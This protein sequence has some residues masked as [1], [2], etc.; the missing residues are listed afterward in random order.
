MI[1]IPEI[2][3]EIVSKEPFLEEAIA[4]GIINYSALARV[5]KPQI[6]EKLLKRI[7][8]GAILMALKR[9]KSK[10][11]PKNDL[12]K[13]ITKTPEMIVRSD[14][15]EYTFVNSGLVLKKISVILSEIADEKR[16]FI[17][18]TQGV[19]E[20]AIIVSSYWQKNIELDLNGEQIVSRLT[21]LSSITL[22]L[23]EENVF[24]PGVYYFIL[25]ALAWEGIN[26]ID[27]V[28]TNSEFTIILKDLEVDRAFSILNKIFR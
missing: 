22:K 6:E 23:P 10:I 20:T 26:I 14:L 12:K 19:F 13:I 3:K 2:T 18:M 16:Y 9:L 15:I 1:T 11:L 5:L 17:T 24:V 4:Q 7:Q 25:K 28:S 27:V 21:N 8:T